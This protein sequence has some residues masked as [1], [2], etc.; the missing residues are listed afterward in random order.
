MDAG[1]WIAVGKTAVRFRV[2]AGASGGS[3]SLYEC[4]VPADAWIAAPH[5]HAGFEE[6]VYG[7]EGTTTWTVDGRSVQVGPG[8]VLC[9]QRGAVHGFAVA[10]GDEA[11]FLCAVTPGLLG[12]EYFEEL[13]EVLAAS[14]RHAPPRD[15]LHEIMLG[16]GLT[17]AAR[18]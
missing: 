14:G 17:P 18:G 12:P 1:P 10:D 7:L 13:G 5:S 6:T 3:L 15:V 2:E 4:R 9:I 16:H 11:T 8:D